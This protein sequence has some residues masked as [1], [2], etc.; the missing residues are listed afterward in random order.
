MTLHPL[1]SEFLIYEEPFV[2]FFISVQMNL[3]PERVDLPDS[4][5]NVSCCHPLD[6]IVHLLETS[7]YPL[8]KHLGFVLHPSPFRLRLTILLQESPQPFL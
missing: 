4:I 7:L 6:L 8:L 2:F 5:S 1:P 3:K